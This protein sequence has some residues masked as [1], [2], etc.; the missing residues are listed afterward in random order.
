L[1]AEKAG[2]PDARIVVKKADAKPL[3]F[4]VL[5]NAFRPMNITHIYNVSSD[6]LSCKV[7]RQNRLTFFVIFS[8]F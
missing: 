3:I 1:A 4:D 7:K 8:R 5:Y 6:V 2:G